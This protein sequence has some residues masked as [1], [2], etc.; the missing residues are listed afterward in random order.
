MNTV[1]ERNRCV[2]D[3]SAQQEYEVLAYLKCRA[4][5]N[6]RDFGFDEDGLADSHCFYDLWAFCG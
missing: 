2:F 1:V 4:L 5:R 3:N 6:F